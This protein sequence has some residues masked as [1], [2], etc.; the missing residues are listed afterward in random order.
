MVFLI[1]RHGSGKS[2]IGD[3][4]AFQGYMHLSLGLLRRIARSGAYP[5]D[6]PAVLVT[7]IGRAPVGPLPMSAAVRLIK[8]A[9]TLDKVVIDGFPSTPE[10]LSIIP[11]T[12][13]YGYVWTGAVERDRRLNHRAEVTPRQWVPGRASARELALP[14]LTAEIRARKRLIFLPNRINSLET[15]VDLASKLLALDR[16]R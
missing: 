15:S 5:S 2:T 14:I 12:A 16:Q 9:Q 4:L 8:F 13:I 1:G 6:I 10:H 7:A 11:E 3:A